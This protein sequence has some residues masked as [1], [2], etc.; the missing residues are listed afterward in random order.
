MKI[1]G[2]V[3]EVWGRRIAVQNDQNSVR[4]NEFAKKRCVWQQFR[5]VRGGMWHLMLDKRTSEA[6]SR[7]QT[8][9]ESVDT[10]V[11][12][13]C[14]ASTPRSFAVG[15]LARWLKQSGQKHQGGSKRGEDRQTE[16]PNHISKLTRISQLLRFLE[17]YPWQRSMNPVLVFE[18]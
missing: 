4:G 1:R 5:S 9:M 17:R 6:I 15:G 10:E 16:T 13:V 11:L 8:A 7:G 3:G 14:L 2:A 12:R 18:Y